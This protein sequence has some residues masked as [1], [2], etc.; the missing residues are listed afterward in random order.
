MA[1]KPRLPL[2]LLPA[3]ASGVEMVAK[4]FRATDPR[5]AEFVLLARAG[6][7]QRRSRRLY[8]YSHDRCPRKSW[9][10]GSLGGPCS[11]GAYCA[12]KLVVAD[13]SCQAWPRQQGQV[14]WPVDAAWP[15]VPLEVADDQPAVRAQRAGYLGKRRGPSA[16]PRRSST[17]RSAA[18][19]RP[20]R[21]AGTRRLG[22]Q[23]D[24]QR[25]ERGAVPTRLAGPRS[26]LR[27]RIRR[28]TCT[29]TTRLELVA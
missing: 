5:V 12:H 11:T 14:G 1:D 20:P 28:G 21:S 19:P 15:C 23:A 17:R 25:V 8:P 16:A 6:G 4:F 24:Q 13:R 9:A 18:V 2:A 29:L 3:E 10:G 7:A 22:V 26:P 27:P